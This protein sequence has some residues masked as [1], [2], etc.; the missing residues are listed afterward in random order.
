MAT[1]K[2]MAKTATRGPAIDPSTV[3]RPRSTFVKPAGGRVRSS[4]EIP[5]FDVALSRR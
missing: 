4:P 1:N 5:R 2:N 3:P